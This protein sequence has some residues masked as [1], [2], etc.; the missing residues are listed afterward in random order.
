M[1]PARAV[2]IAAII[3][4]PASIWG[5]VEQGKNDLVYHTRNVAGQV[6][7]APIEDGEVFSRFF[8]KLRFPDGNAPV[9]QSAMTRLFQEL[10]GADMTRVT[11]GPEFKAG[12]P[13]GGA[14]LNGREVR[15][16]NGGQPVTVRWVNCRGS[17]YLYPEG[18]SAG[19]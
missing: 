18:D 10:K 1:T 7:K 4:I 3:A 2:T 15:I 12:N 17:W 8:D 19:S 14:D 6:K 9:Q 13:Q 11:L 16:E 5:L